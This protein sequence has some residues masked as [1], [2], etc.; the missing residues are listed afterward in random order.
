M[1]LMMLVAHL[2]DIDRAIFFSYLIHRYFYFILNYILFAVRVCMCMSL[3]AVTGMRGVTRH[4]LEGFSFHCLGLC[5]R[6]EE[7]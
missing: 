4:E 7:L 5:T 3:D 2:R 1:F 6:S